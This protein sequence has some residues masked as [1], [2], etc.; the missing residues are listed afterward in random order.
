LPLPVETQLY[1]CIMP[2]GSI[3]MVSIFP[4][5]SAP[6]S[7]SSFTVA[8]WPFAV[9]ACRAVYWPL[10]LLL[11]QCT[12]APALIS[13]F[14]DAVWPFDDATCRALNLHAMTIWQIGC[15]CVCRSNVLQRATQIHQERSVSIFGTSR[16]HTLQSLGT[17]RSQNLFV[18]FVEPTTDVL[19][20]RQPKCLGVTRRRDAWTSALPK[21]LRV[22]K[23]WISDSLAFLRLSIAP[24]FCCASSLT[25]EALANE[26]HDAVQNRTRCRPCRASPRKNPIWSLPDS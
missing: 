10:P 20:Q 25:L 26:L 7:R 1:L 16:I 3:S 14:T 9:A 15:T 11:L 22:W 8:V 21:P 4:C 19:D 6:A 12:F 23:P 13:I 2:A 17:K 18:V 24:G 5:T